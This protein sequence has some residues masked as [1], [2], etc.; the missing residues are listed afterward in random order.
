KRAFKSTGLV[1][2]GMFE[3]GP[4]AYDRPKTGDTW[5]PWGKTLKGQWLET[6]QWK[7]GARDP[8]RPA[9]ANPF[10]LY[11]GFNS[12]HDPRQAPKEYADRYPA[13]R[14][15]IPPNYLPEHPF[16][17]GDHRVRDEKLAP[18]P[19]TREAVQVHR[20]EYY[21]HARK[22]RAR[23]QSI[24]DL[25][26][27]PRAGGWAARADGQAASVRSQH[28]HAADDRRAGNSRGQACG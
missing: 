11:P 13:E 28:T 10:F 17:E 18:W 21:A 1:S 20:A 7:P 12:P 14:N 19:R 23:E 4:E 2:G 9:Q 6:T 27:G 16:E 22:I 26:G 5:T 3:S 15:R 25:H 24:R 8:M